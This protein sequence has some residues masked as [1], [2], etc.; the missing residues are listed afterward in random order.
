MQEFT[1][2]PKTLPFLENAIA[3]MRNLNLPAIAFFFSFKTKEGVMLGTAAIV[4]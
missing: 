2:I 4:L 1:S 3:A